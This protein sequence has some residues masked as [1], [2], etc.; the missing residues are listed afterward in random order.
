[1]QWRDRHAQFGC[2]LTI[3]AV[4]AFDAAVVAGIILLVKLT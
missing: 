4:L 2:F 3:L 1:M